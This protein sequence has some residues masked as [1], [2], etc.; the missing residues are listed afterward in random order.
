MHVYYNVLFVCVLHPLQSH[1]VCF[2]ELKKLKEFWEIADTLK[3]S[4]VHN[5]IIILMLITLTVNFK[6]SCYKF[7]CCK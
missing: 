3:R 6:H 5:Y 2:Q 7:S 4:T 1:P